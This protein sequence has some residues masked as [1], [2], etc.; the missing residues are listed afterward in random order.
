MV[1]F[2]S[3]A[4][5]D[6]CRDTFF[7][8]ELNC[9]VQGTAIYIRELFRGLKTERLSRLQREGRESSYGLQRM[10]SCGKRNLLITCN[11]SPCSACSREMTLQVYFLDE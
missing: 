6:F 4:V 3:W 11:S 9:T 2:N 5:R 1:I 10:V 7:V 8:C